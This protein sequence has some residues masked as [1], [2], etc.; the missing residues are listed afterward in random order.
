M[1]KWNPTLLPLTDQTL[2]RVPLSH[3]PGGY[4]KQNPYVPFIG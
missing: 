2:F 3:R 4:V 1:E